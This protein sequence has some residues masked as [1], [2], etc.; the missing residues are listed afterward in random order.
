[1]K[2]NPCPGGRPCGTTISTNAF[3]TGRPVRPGTVLPVDLASGKR[4]EQPE[5]LPDRQAMLP[6]RVVSQPAGF[7]KIEAIL[8]ATRGATLS[9]Q[10]I[11]R[12]PTTPAPGALAGSSRAVD[13]PAV[14]SFTQHAAPG[15]R[16]GIVY[17]AASGL[18]VNEPRPPSGATQAT[19][20]LS[21]RPLPL[22]P[23]A[24]GLRAVQPSS[25][26]PPK[27]VPR[28]APQGHTEGWYSPPRPDFSSSAAPRSGGATVGGR[29]PGG[30]A[31]RG[32]D[33]S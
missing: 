23:G 26:T 28:A 4:I 8:K 31:S 9:S 2:N 14:G 1:G 11:N 6:G 27:L 30:T 33:A 15:P 19:N 22:A 18:Y 16:A 29:G 13:R 20:E 3:Q 5:I 21:I 12:E 17:D 24:A 25:G 7:A 10:A 32:G